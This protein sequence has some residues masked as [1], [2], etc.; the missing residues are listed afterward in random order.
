MDKKQA[1]EYA[2]GHKDMV[3][4]HFLFG[5]GTKRHAD[6]A[7]HKPYPGEMALLMLYVQP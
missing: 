3:Q 1:T 4:S 7:E 5:C 6:N 2:G